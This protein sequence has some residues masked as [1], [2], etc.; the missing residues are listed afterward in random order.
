MATK[1]RLTNKLRTENAK[2]TKK[3]KGEILGRLESMDMAHSA[4]RRLLKAPTTPR[5]AKPWQAWPQAALFVVAK[6]GGSE[7]VVAAVCFV[8][9]GH[10]VLFMEIVELAND[11][12]ISV[13]I[14]ILVI[15]LFNQLVKCGELHH[16]TYLL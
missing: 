1:K 13:L 5:P 4:A 8:K 3:Q 15:H 16:G 10:V 2:G 14:I 9:L 11:V 12:H 6:T 7:A